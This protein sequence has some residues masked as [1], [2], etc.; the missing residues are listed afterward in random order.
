MWNSPYRKVQSPKFKEIKNQKAKID[1]DPQGEAEA[2]FQ[3][4]IEVA[5]QQQAKSLVEN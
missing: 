1:T 4:A 2:C 5:R 3:K